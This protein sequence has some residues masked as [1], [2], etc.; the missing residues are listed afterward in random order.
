[1]SAGGLEAEVRGLV[2]LDLEGLRT[3]WG[4]RYGAPPRMRSADL[5]RRRLAWR[6]QVDAWGGLDA[7]TLKLL[8]GKAMASHGPRAREGA[9][10]VREYQ[11]ERHEAAVTPDGVEY[12][13][14]VYAS[15]S[16]VAR[17][18]TGVRWNGPRFFGLRGGA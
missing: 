18:I 8:R 14:E 5:L 11:G 16:E 3:A 1:M 7:E 10:L 2:T 6:M 4:G 15:L 9:R 17:V 12:R 13:G